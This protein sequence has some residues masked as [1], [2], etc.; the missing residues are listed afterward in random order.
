MRRLLAF[1][2]GVAAGVVVTRQ[3]HDRPPTDFWARPVG[4][5][6]WRRGDIPIGGVTAL[7]FSAVAPRAVGR[8]LRPAGLGAIAGCLAVAVSDP[9]EA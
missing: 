3:I 5:L 1:G 8:W 9:L 2:S 7:L 6:G 4:S